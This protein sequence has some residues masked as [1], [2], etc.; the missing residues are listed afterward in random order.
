MIS[1]FEKIYHCDNQYRLLMV[2]QG[3]LFEAAEAAISHSALNSVVAIYN[4]VPNEKN[5]GTLPFIRMLC[6][7]EY[8]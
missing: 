1:I 8:T 5:V 4:K 3:E 6:E 7:F 2:G